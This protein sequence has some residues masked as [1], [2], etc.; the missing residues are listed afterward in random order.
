MIKFALLLQFVQVPEKDVNGAKTVT[1]LFALEL[2]RIV[3]IV[4]NDA[5]RI[6]LNV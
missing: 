1:R 3:P 5:K 4:S 6:L 2:I